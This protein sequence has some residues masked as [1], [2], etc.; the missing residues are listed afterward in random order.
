MIDTPAERRAFWQPFVL[1]YGGNRFGK[2][3]PGWPLLLAIGVALGQPWLV[4]ALLAALAVALTYRL[5]REIYDPATGLVA[6]LLTA[7]SP[8]FLLLSGSLMS[9]TASLFW[10][11]LLIYALWRLTRHVQAR[12][13]LLGGIALGMLI[14]TRP[15]TAVGLFL[16]FALAG[17]L[18]VL[19]PAGRLLPTATPGALLRHIAA[20]RTA[21]RRI[22][23]AA[24]SACGRAPTGLTCAP[25]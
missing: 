6:A 9:H 3:T 7:I 25:C 22:I 5:G 4:N 16:P 8:T 15:L 13:A 11:V 10:G 12:W 20:R 21:R 14:I 23:L 1:D 17:T 2:Y 18:A 24:G 19:L